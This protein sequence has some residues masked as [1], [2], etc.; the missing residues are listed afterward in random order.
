VHVALALPNPYH[1]IFP[2]VFWKKS[3]D[4][5]EFSGSTSCPAVPDVIVPS[6]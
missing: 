3:D 2:D 4:L 5:E 1:M 6:A